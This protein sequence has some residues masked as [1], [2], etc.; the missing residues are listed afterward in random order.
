MVSGASLLVLISPLCLCWTE[1]SI[2]Q[3]IRVLD[4]FNI[5]FCELKSFEHADSMLN[6]RRWEEAK[7]GAL[8]GHPATNP[9]PH[10]LTF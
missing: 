10:P 9:T 7:I 4:N 1:M 2:N 3:S 8:A 6:V 5:S